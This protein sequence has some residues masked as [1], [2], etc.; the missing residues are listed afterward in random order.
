M[1]V[2]IQGGAM[3]LF[4]LMERLWPRDG[5]R[6]FA[7]DTWL[8]LWTGGG[9]FALRT[10][11]FFAAGTVRGPRLVDLSGITHPL[12]QFAFVFVLSDLA[13]YWLHRMHHSVA[14]FWQFHRVHHSSETLNVTAGLRMHLVDFIQLATLPWVL[15]SVLFDTSSF[16]PRIWLALGATVAVMDAFSHGDIRFPMTH[17]V[18]RA[19]DKVLNNPHFHCWHHT[20]DG[21]KLDGNYGQALTLWDRLFGSHIDMPEPPEALGLPDDQ[22]IALSVVG[23]QLLR[24]GRREVA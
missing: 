2:L 11:V 16:D 6:L 13:R 21:E 8:N 17:R 23:M 18:A 1:A 15:F 22:I 12:L 5:I 10:A 19:W 9:L 7:R 24:P 4:L 14:F 3:V 20:R